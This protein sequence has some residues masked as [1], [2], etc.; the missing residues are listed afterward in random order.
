MQSGQL[1]N[2]HLSDQ[3][4]DVSQLIKMEKNIAVQEIK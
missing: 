3:K 1:S 2:Q 4:L